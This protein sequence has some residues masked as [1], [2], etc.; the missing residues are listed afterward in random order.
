[1]NISKKIQ[2]FTYTPTE[3]VLISELPNVDDISSIMAVDENNVPIKYVDG[4]VDWLQ[5]LKYLKTN[6]GYMIKSKLSATLPYELYPSIDDIPESVTISQ[7]LQIA[8]YCGTGFNLLGITITSQPSND[9]LSGDT[10]SFSVE[11]TVVGGVSLTYQWQISTDDGANWNDINGETN[12][13]LNLSGLSSNDVGNQ[14]RVIVGATGE[15]SVTSNT[16]AILS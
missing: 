8:T 13:T 12:A 3:T 5:T 11:A 1:M 2:F 16:A 7:R 15:D 4:V 9:E 6:S 10:A 14:Y